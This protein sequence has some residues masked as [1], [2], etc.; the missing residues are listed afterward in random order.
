MTDSL[1]FNRDAE[2]GVISGLLFD[3]RNAGF[4]SGLSGYHFS[5]SDIGK[6]VEAAHRIIKRGERADETTVYYELRSEKWA[7]DKMVEISGCDTGAMH[8]AEAAAKEVK[9]CYSR[10][11]IRRNMLTIADKCISEVNIDNLMAFISDAVANSTESIS[12]KES[13]LMAAVMQDVWNMIDIG[14]PAVQHLKTGINA[15]DNLT[16]GYP[17]GAM[18]IIGAR[19]SVGKT[20]YGGNLVGNWSLA[21]KTGV[22]FTLEDK[23]TVLISRIIARD[24]Q[25]NIGRITHG[26]VK[27]EEHGPILDAINAHSRSNIHIEDMSGLTVAKMRAIATGIKNKYGT[28]DFMLVDHLAHIPLPPYTKKY[29]GTS[30]N[31][32]ELACTIKELDCAGP[33]L[34]QL[35]RD[36]VKR[37]DPRP[38]LEDL[39]DSGDIEQHARAVHMLFVPSQFDKDADEHDYEL[40]VRKASMGKTGT[41]ELYRDSS[42]MTISD[43]GDISNDGY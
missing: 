2:I 28:L 21:G 33:V 22:V 19:P 38:D 37:T 5:D 41:V 27:K 8:N 23:D 39:K 34:H 11:I 35:N 7:M 26:F 18:A 12:G 29:D 3:N 6:L 10:R 30:K 25:I 24:A 14:K 31:S 36:S 32:Y 43:R 20:M 15:I 13:P 4:T 17:H 9:N 16:G 40:I 1:L 42:T